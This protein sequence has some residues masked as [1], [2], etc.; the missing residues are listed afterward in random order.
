MPRKSPA[1]AASAA[2]TIYRLKIVLLGGAPPIWRR[3]EVPDISLE[4]LHAVIQTVMPWHS[5]HLWEF[6]VGRDER[7]GM[8]GDSQYGFGMDDDTVTADIASGFHALNMP[9]A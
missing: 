4:S 2:P 3:V 1:T 9:A 5:S 7:Y 6:V 8:S